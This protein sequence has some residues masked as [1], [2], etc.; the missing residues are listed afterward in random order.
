MRE[1][2]R[3]LTAEDY[4]RA[5]ALFTKL[6]SLPEGP[7]SPAALELLALSRERKGQ[8]A[9]ARAEYERYL[10][11]YPFDPGAE[12]V[13]QRLEALVTA[14]ADPPSRRSAPTR[15]PEQRS[16]NFETFGS[17]YAAYRYDGRQTEDLGDETLDSSLFTD[18]HADNRLNAGGWSLR[19]QI[20]GGYRHG[21][22]DGGSG[23]TRIS[24]LFLEAETSEGRFVGSVGRRSKST[25][26]VLG[27]YDGGEATFRVG[28]LWS[29]GA[30]AGLP[31]DSS[32][33]I[34][35]GFDRYFA[36][37]NTE[38]GPLFDVLNVELFAIAQMAEGF[39][40]RTAIGAEI[41]YFDQGRSASAFLDYDVYY[42][43]LN[44]AHVVASWQPAPT[45][46]LTLFG[47]YRNAP[48]LTTRNALQGQGV[49]DLDDLETLFSR[50]E[51]EQI[52]RDRT[53]RS[54]NV[55]LSASQILTDHY[56]LALD[57]GASHLSDTP[58]SGG[59]EAIE[60][61]GFEFNYSAQFIANHVL[62]PGDVGVVGL[63]YFDGSNTDIVSGT[64]S[65]RYPL[66]RNLRFT[67]RFRADYR[68]QEQGGPDTVVLQ[69]LL[70]FDLT[71]W[72]LRLDA[73]VGVEWEI[74]GAEDGLAYFTTC[75]ARY[76]F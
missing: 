68:M 27:R 25:G 46:F 45:T 39:V 66:T 58:A 4:G 8:L 16:L 2:R 34:F 42:Q 14:R 73:E 76:D 31:V 51:I 29:V 74:G 40:D 64:L 72:V 1:G 70:R 3:A 44:T 75:G 59:L 32:S 10:E 17:L 56:Q 5:S 20:T 36:G 35:V 63:R 9:H 61:T 60:G 50:E 12:R 26:G 6:L 54:A 30:V 37:V 19:N 24:S 15:R 62:M 48:T 52:A 23:D 53:A 67:P 28:E 7:D 38:I 33:D 49:V 41:R 71:V 65:G 47:D 43:S 13:R 22:L 11:R 57:V 55:S 18:V 21:F 69:P